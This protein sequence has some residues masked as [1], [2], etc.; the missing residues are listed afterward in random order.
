MATRTF[1]ELRGTADTWCTSLAYWLGIYRGESTAEAMLDVAGALSFQYDFEEQADRYGRV[2][3][4]DNEWPDVFAPVAPIQLA[5]SWSPVPLA[6]EILGDPLLETA[7]DE[8]RRTVAVSW[9]MA[10]DLKVVA[11]RVRSKRLDDPDHRRFL[12]LLTAAALRVGERK[13]CVLLI[14]KPGWDYEHTHPVSRQTASLMKKA[15]FVLTTR[16]ARENA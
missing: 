5:R 6:V 2:F 9:S 10:G 3:P 14:A 12:E 11:R 1:D 15:G 8:E 4:E 13:A 7:T 16:T